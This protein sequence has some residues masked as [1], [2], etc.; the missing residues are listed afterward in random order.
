MFRNLLTGSEIKTML[1]LFNFLVRLLLV[2]LKIHDGFLGQFQ[3]T[4]K[5]SLGPLQV[6][7]HLLLLLQRTL[8]LHINI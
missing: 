5:L 8:K 2:I 4:L 6:H 3:I 7:T 1:L